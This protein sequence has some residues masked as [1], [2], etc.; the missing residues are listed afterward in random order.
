MRSLIKKKDICHF[1]ILSI[2]CSHQPIVCFQ[3]D[4]SDP[5]AQH[6]LVQAISD[7]IRVAKNE[8]HKY[9]EESLITFVFCIRKVNPDIKYYR[10][11]VPPARIHAIRHF[12]EPTKYNPYPDVPGKSSG[13][14]AWPKC[15]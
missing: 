2:I 9:T 12:L 5:I 1:S 3:M 11:L 10:D 14:K 6:P 13:I 7:R 4:P 15:R 8:K